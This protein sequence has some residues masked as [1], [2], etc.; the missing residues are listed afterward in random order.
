[1][2]LFPNRGCPSCR[3]SSLVRHARGNHHQAL[4]VDDGQGAQQQTIDDAEDR[5]VGSDA[6]A[7]RQDGRPS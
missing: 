5:G 7:E 2:N 6:E 1:M 4:W 3:V